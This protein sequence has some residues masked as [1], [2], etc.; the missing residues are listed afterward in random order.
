MNKK[1]AHLLLIFTFT[2]LIVPSLHPVLANEVFYPRLLGAPDI[3]CAPSPPGPTC[4][5][6]VADYAAYFFVLA[7]YLAGIIGVVSIAFAGVTILINAGS[8]SAV[9]AARERIIGSILGIVILMCSFII[10]RTINPDLITPKT[11]GGILDSTVYGVYL[12][13]STT[14]S[15]DHPDGYLYN[16]APVAMPNTAQAEIQIGAQL[17]Y[18]CP[19]TTTNPKTLLVWLYDGSDY[20]DGGNSGTAELH[21]NQAIV[22]D[23][24][25]SYQW[26]WKEAGVYFYATNDCTGISSDVQKV[27]GPIQPFDAADSI[28]VGSMKIVSGA[29]ADSKYGV[30]LTEGNIDENSI[31]SGECSQPYVNLTQGD[32][33]CIPMPN[34]SNGNTFSPLAAYVFNVNP[35]YRTSG[36][37]LWLYSDAKSLFLSSNN[38][39]TE[40]PIENPDAFLDKWGE[41]NGSG[42]TCDPTQQLCLNEIRIGNNNYNVFL[43]AENDAE[44]P[45]VDATCQ[46]FNVDQ[47]IQDGT[48]ILSNGRHLIEMDVFPY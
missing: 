23:Q 17:Y 41:N 18:Y 2:L 37:G 47:T 24:A 26:K 6:S 32:S 42:T 29:T 4:T 25:A 48:D 14:P 38:I 35:N 9:G 13:W 43:Y 28:P 46:A 21:C 22:V 5:I 33:E 16:T 20:Q 1:F 3:N 27:D 10:L 44:A 34:G 31:A 40:L 36:N 15:I 45:N 39:G 8:P 12:R 19:P 30:V 11:G 7:I